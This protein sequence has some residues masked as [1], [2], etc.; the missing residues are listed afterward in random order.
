MN[1]EARFARIV[2]DGGHEAFFD[3]FLLAAEI[4]RLVIVSP[5]V[6]SLRDERITLR[7]ILANIEA[8]RVQTTVVMRH[9]GKEPLNYQAAELLTE[10]RFV[11]LYVN[12]DLHAKVYVCRCAPFGFALVGSANLSGRAT[13]AHEIGVL[14][15]GKGAGR[16]IVEELDLLGTDDLPNRSGTLLY[17]QHGL[18]VKPWA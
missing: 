10:S 14:I 18:M 17:A 13:R 6:T 16:D 7:D 2:Y 9:P 4:S 1:W 8:Q 11:T 12:N 5:W 15:E 3:R